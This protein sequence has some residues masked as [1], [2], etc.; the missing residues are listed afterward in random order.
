MQMRKTHEPESSSSR[1]R[2]CSSTVSS[3]NARHAPK[4]CWYDSR[5]LNRRICSVNRMT[6]SWI[7]FALRSSGGVRNEF[8]HVFGTKLC[9]SSNAPSARVVD[10]VNGPGDGGRPGDGERPGDG[11]RTDAGDPCRRTG[12]G[13]AGERKA[14]GDALEL[15]VAKST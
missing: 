3:L 6:S 4:A 15:M 1:M 14:A 5:L 11:D 12:A 9:C 13:D 7:C 2:L 10:S 8:Q